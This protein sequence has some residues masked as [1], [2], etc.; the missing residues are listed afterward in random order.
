MWRDAAIADAQHRYPLESCGLVAG[1]IYVPAINLRSEPD[2]F[3]IDPN[4]WVEASEHGP[5]T[6]LVHSH[7]D[8][9]SDLSPFDKAQPSRSALPWVVIAVSPAGVDIREHPAEPAPLYGRM[10][11][12][13]IHD[14]FGFIRDW[15]QVERGIALPDADR[16]GKWWDRAEDRYPEY[17]AGQGFVQVDAPHLGDIILMKIRA[18]VPNHAAVYLGS[19]QIGHHAQGLLSQRTGYAETY[20]RLTHS[21]WRLA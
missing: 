2:M 10:F 7:P 15:F 6:H 9:T 1:G 5:V 3:S 17:L 8:G 4:A 19:G 21:I 12:Y 20:R 18:K 11:L 16:M 14:C 13:G